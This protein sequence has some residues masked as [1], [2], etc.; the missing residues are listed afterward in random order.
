MEIPAV[1]P[2]ATVLREL[3]RRCAAAELIPRFQR[4][5]HSVKADG[6]LVTEADLAMQRAVV[7]QLEQL[8][9][10]IPV[11]GEESPD[12]I[13]TPVFDAAD[14][15]FWCLDPLD[16]T[17]N[18]AAGMPFFSVSLALIHARRPV[19]GAIYDPVRDEFFH[20]Q[21]GRGAFLNEQRLMAPAA[22]VRPPLHHGIGL[23]DFKRL[24]AALAA[25]LATQPPYASQRSFGSVAL[26]WCWIAAARAHVYLHGKQKIWD[27]AAGWLILDEAGGHSATL[28]GDVVFDG[29]FT[30]RSAVAALDREVFDAWRRWLAS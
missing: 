24:D 23:V 19:F 10:A 28:G 17:T 29:S 9:P 25:R 14:A 26:D 12:E 16:G 2:S 13:V 27:Y 20:A 15:A 22:G 1:V 6:S 30:S 4:A 8:T 7:A 11:L 5:N 21:R 3:L 18:F